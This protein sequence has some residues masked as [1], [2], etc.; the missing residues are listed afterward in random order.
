MDGQICDPVVG[1]CSPNDGNC[2]L[3]YAEQQSANSSIASYVWTALLLLLLC[4]A[5]LIAFVIY[6][7]RKYQKERDPPLPTVSFHPRSN[8]TDKNNS[9]DNDYGTTNLGKGGAGTIV[10][11][12][13]EFENRLFEEPEARDSGILDDELAVLAQ[14]EKALFKRQNNGRVEN[15]YASLDDHDD[16]GYADAVELFGA[17]GRAMP[18]QSSSSTAANNVRRSPPRRP[19]TQ[20]ALGGQ[21]ANTGF[22]NPNSLLTAT[23]REAQPSTALLSLNSPTSPDA[24]GGEMDQRNHELNN[25]EEPLS[26]QQKKQKQ[27]DE[28]KGSGG[29]NF[30][31]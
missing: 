19:S 30:Y 16:D 28:R 23:S 31:S 6:Y 18:G 1:C 8:G 13:I 26:E 29:G 10:E 14:K 12:K 11:P 27:L 17:N 21:T 5:T 3:A 24:G 2:G 25:Y 4:S 7:R 15:E 22:D 9:V 20:P